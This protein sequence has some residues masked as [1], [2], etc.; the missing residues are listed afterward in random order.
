M[1]FTHQFTVNAPIEAVADFHSQ[2]AS[3]GAITPP[4]IIVNI[5]HAPE[6][7]TDG[8]Q[9]AFTMW[10]GPLPIRWVAEISKNDEHAFV[11]RQVEGPFSVWEHRH[12]FVDIGNGQ[13]EVHDEVTA[14][15]S[16]NWFWKTLGY[17]M[18]LNMPVL[19]AFR[20][21]KTKRILSRKPKETSKPSST[22]A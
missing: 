13:T 4:P 3:M 1:K 21:W 2:S 6:I 8:D 20:A 11:D 5:H 12:T 19:F 16:T 18:W 9:M 22:Y 10:M 15:L 17:G 14:E 7:L